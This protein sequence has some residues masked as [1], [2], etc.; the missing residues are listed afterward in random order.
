[1]SDDRR[2][3]I[4]PQYFNDGNGGG[5]GANYFFQRYFGVGLEG[6]WWD[7]AR[8]GITQDQYDNFLA[9]GKAVPKNF[10]RKLCSQV[11]AN[12]ILRYPMEFTSFGV[13]P[14]IFG[15]GGALFSNQS[16]GFSDAG[17]G[18]E[19]RLTPQVGIF[20]DWRW[21]F[22]TGGNRNDETTTRAGLRF[23]F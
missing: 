21:N 22:V 18:V 20:S 3:V 11:T 8:P 14:Y 16:C 17:A 23:V 19:V 13:A 9:K 7:G 1:M 15:G 4:Q 10:G 5:V 6:N 2:S 12:L